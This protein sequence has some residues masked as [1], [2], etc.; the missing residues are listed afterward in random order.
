[1]MRKTLVLRVQVNVRPESKKNCCDNYIC[2]KFMT[3]SVCFILCSRQRL[4]LNEL[5]VDVTYRCGTAGQVQD[6]T[7]AAVDIL[8]DVSTKVNVHMKSKEHA[9][10]HH[11]NESGQRAAGV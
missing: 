6:P 3:S 5:T 11:G 8:N 7:V 2:N 10:R 9:D 1:M 4:V